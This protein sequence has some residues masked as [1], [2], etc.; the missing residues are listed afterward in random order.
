MREADAANVVPLHAPTALSGRDDDA[1][2]ALA[3]ADH[4]PAFEVLAHRYLA[5]IAGYAAKYLGDTGAGDDV[6]QEVLLEAWLLR[7]HYRGSGRLAAFLLTIARNRCRNAARN[8]WRRSA[9]GHALGAGPPAG[10]AES[11]DQLDRL[12]D[13]ERERRV[14]EVMLRMPDKHREALLLRIDQGLAYADMARM[15]GVPQVTVRSRVHHALR[16][17]REELGEDAQ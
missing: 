9:A 3:A 17:L 6:A 10:A 4:R 16:R 15:L 2:M 5:R 8:A 11:G 14:L 1:L 7:A 13:A 12:L